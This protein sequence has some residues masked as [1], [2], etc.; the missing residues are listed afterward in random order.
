[1]IVL[2]PEV[3]LEPG[4]RTQTHWM[5]AVIECTQKMI[6]ALIDKVK[7]KQLKVMARKSLPGSKFE[8]E[9]CKVAAQHPT[10]SM[11]APKTLLLESAYPEVWKFA[12]VE[13]ME[14]L[15]LSRAMIMILGAEDL[16]KS[17]VIREGS[18]A[19]VLNMQTRPR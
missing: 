7:R 14:Q 16:V 3:E 13:L 8:G 18:R 11:I 1:V 12:S 2:L 19:G 6:L 9:F 5:G 10:C 17:E 4:T 15:S